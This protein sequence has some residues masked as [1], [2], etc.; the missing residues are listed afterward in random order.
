MVQ[1][2]PQRSMETPRYEGVFWVLALPKSSTPKGA[3]AVPLT[4]PEIKQGKPSDKPCKHRRQ[5]AAL[6][7]SHGFDSPPPSSRG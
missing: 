3:D 6:A 5:P 2:V 7:A 4:A 1:D